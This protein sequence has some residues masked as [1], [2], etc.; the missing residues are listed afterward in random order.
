MSTIRAFNAHQI[1][2]SEFY[3]HVDLNSGAWYLKTTTTRAFALWLD[4]VCLLYI[5]TVTLSFVVFDIAEGK[6]I[7]FARLANIVR[8]LI[9]YSFFFS[10]F[11]YLGHSGNVGLVILQCINMIGMCQWGMRQTAEIENQMTSVERVMEYASLPSEPPLESLPQY[12]PPE[13]WPERGEIEFRDLNFRYSEHS[14]FVLKDINIQIKAK[15]FL[16]N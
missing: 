1:L 2:Q 15:V 9:K 13:T 16:V 6:G 5:S 11:F 8:I 14:N 10:F 4:L 12:R 3:N 7:A